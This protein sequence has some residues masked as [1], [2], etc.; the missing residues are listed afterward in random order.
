MQID[1]E[2]SRKQRTFLFDLVGYQ[3]TP[4]Q[5]A[6]HFS[7]LEDP[8]II[9]KWVSGGEQSGKSKSAAM[10]L[11]GRVPEG[12]VWWLVGMDY[13]NCRKEFEYC[14]EVAHTSNL[15]VSGSLPA[16]GQC[17][18]TM[19]GGISLKTI[20]LKDL[21][22]VGHE[23][24]NGVLVCEAAQVKQ[25][26]ITRIRT[27]VTG[28]GG[29][30]Q[31]SGTLEGSLGW[32]ARTLEEYKTFNQYGA[33]SFFIP[34]WTNPHWYPLG[35]DDP[36][37]QAA[38]AKLQ[39][40]VFNERF[41]GMP[42][43][44]SRIVIKWFDPEIHVGFYEFDTDLPVEIAIDPGGSN[45]SGAYS[46]LAIQE[47][48]DIVYVIDE[49]YTLG[50]VTEDI[51]EHCQT[52]PWWHKVQAGIV[53]IAAKQHNTAA[54]SKMP[55]DWDIWFQTTGLGLICSKIDQGAGIDRMGSYL[56]VDQ[57]TRKPHLLVN[58]RCKGLICECASGNPPDGFAEMGPWLRHKETGKPIDKD[59]HS[60]KALYYYLINRHGFVTADAMLVGAVSHNS[61][62]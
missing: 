42:V 23:S 38:L 45:K 34:S 28:A 26:A 19:A 17:N 33:K 32:Y 60:V 40:D 36:K 59:N 6:M 24:P 27:R 21:S 18:M 61:M 43:K 49:V 35:Y 57:V 16:E 46:V 22:K 8:S 1:P 41:A 10:E 20:S 12:L 47:K 3:P 5:E 48:D 11:M 39:P 52:K 53:D 37:I 4:E 55:S 15:F 9:E 30:I 25:E 7:D 58:Y 56:K 51:I 13:F 50:L 54:P 62:M 29:W 14:W 31:C 2:L 44:S